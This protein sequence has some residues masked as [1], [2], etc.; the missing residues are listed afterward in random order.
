MYTLHAKMDTDTHALIHL[1]THVQYLNSKKKIPR[2][3]G[4]GVAHRV[5]G[6]CPRPH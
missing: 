4:Q 5:G 1:Y 6:T 3:W 2:L